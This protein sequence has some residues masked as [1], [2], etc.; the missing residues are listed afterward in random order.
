MGVLCSLLA[1]QSA[2][3]ADYKKGMFTQ[4]KAG[5]PQ[6]NT[7]SLFLANAVFIELDKDLERLGV[8]FARYADDIV[9]VARSY[10]DACEASELIFQW[11]ERSKVDVNHKK[12][13]GISLLTAQDPGEIKSKCSIIF[14]GCEISN[15]GVRPAEKRIK[16]IKLKIARVVHKHLIQAPKRRTFNRERI[17]PDVDWDLVNCVNAIRR[18][19]YGRLSESDLTDGLNRKGAQK[20]IRSHMSGLAMVDI[21]DRFRELDGWLVGILERSYAMRASLVCKLGVKPLGLTRKAI[22][23]GD[24]YKFDKFTGEM[25]LPSAFRAW[26]YMRRMYKSLGV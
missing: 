2:V 19:L 25:R 11:S 6:G 24:W 3:E 13:D 8:T 15:L 26:L 17:Q 4:R 18:I 14:L 12:S 5:I 9:V 22:I 7:I 21:P 10:S 16:R 23:R 1:G 20:L